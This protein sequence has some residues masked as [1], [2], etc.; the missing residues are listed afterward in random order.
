MAGEQDFVRDV[1]SMGYPGLELPV[2][3]MGLRNRSVC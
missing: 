2:K 3:S 1:K